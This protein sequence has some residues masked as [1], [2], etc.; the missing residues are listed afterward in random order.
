MNYFDNGLG[1]AAF[2]MLPFNFIHK[3]NHAPKEV[4]VNLSLP[5]F[6]PFFGAT[7]VLVPRTWQSF[8]V[9][10]FTWRYGKLVLVLPCV[11]TP[12]VIQ[13]GCVRRHNT[14]RLFSL[15]GSRYNIFSNFPGRGGPS[16]DE[17]WRIQ[18]IQIPAVLR[19]TFS[20]FC[21]LFPSS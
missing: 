18:T 21:V 20:Y 4:V 3:N 16:I 15:K 19:F 10:Y 7:Y 12:K 14:L 6:F 2:L 8:V 9:K 5:L 1:V 13:Q 11:D 17:A